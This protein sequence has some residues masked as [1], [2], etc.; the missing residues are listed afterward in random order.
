MPERATCGWTPP[1]AAELARWQ[2]EHPE[3]ISTGTVTSLGLRATITSPLIYHGT[4]ATQALELYAK[5]PEK[6]R[7]VPCLALELPEQ[8]V[9]NKRILKD[10]WLGFYDF[11]ARAFGLEWSPLTF[12]HELFHHVQVYTLTAE[13]WRA[14]ETFWRANK[15]R[16]PERGRAS[17][18][19][20]FAEGAA[21]LYVRG[22]E[23]AGGPAV[24]EK[25]GE[26][27]A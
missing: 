1:S 3:A 21:H 15:S 11:R 4:H 13:Q 7:A 20:G 10:R 9:F 27:L 12:V 22:V 24:A 5:L 25:I 6:A 17:S 19:E 8:G 16:L 2:Q 23:A 18:W 26:L 14:W